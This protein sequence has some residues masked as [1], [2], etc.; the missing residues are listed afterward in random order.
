MTEWNLHLWEG[1]SEYLTA[2]KL[3][4]FD[5]KTIPGGAGHLPYGNR[6]KAQLKKE[7]RYGEFYT[8]G[9]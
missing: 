5:A 1:Y 9:D 7:E 8:Q 4:V 3:P 6:P 2:Q